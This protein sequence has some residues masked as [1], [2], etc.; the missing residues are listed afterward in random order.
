M[1]QALTF[2]QARHRG[3]T[4]ERGAYQGTT[5]DRHDRWYVYRIDTHNAVDRRGSG[6]RTRR[7]ALEAL[8]DR[9]G[10]RYAVDSDSYCDIANDAIRAE[11]NSQL[12]ETEAEV[13]EEMLWDRCMAAL[14]EWSTEHNPAT[15]EEIEDAVTKAY[16][17]IIAD[18]IG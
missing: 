12:T 14:P 4:I 7:E 8:D 3:W 15:R 1:A 17:P 13:S 5:D 2:E 18:A 9:L 16:R 11:I 10:P 6:Y